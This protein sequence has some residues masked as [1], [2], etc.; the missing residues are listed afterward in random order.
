[1]LALSPPSQSPSQAP[2]H[3]KTPEALSLS[4]CS[5][6]PSTGTGLVLLRGGL[7]TPGAWSSGVCAP[8]ELASSRREGSGSCAGPTVPSGLAHEQISLVSKFIDCC[9]GHKA[10]L[11]ERKA[12]R[13]PLSAGLACPGSQPAIHHEILTWFH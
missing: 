4:L 8:A 12:P 2:S 6:P 7:G 1:M 13:E 9:S 11:S 5:S 10:W 3:M